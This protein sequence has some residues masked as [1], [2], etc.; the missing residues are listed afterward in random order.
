MRQLNLHLRT[1]LFL[2]D[3]IKYVC[4]C[5]TCDTHTH[6]HTSVISSRNV[7][8]GFMSRQVLIVEK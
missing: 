1:K 7:T 5:I 8:I 6:T 2:I 4:K 3:I